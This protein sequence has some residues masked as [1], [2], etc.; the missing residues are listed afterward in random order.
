MKLNNDNFSH[1]VGIF[2]NLCLLQR[3]LSENDTLSLQVAVIYILLF[4][5]T[6]GKAT[7]KKLIVYHQ[8]ISFPLMLHSA[9]FSTKA[10]EG[11]AAISLY[12]PKS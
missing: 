6:T 8:G 2:S 10:V 1:T 12:Q 4:Y 3:H 11:E 7:V 9:V 5:W